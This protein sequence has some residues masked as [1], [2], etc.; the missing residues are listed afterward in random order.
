MRKIYTKTVFEF[1]PTTDTFEVNQEESEFHYIP[2]DAPLTL[3]GGSGGGDV[4]SQVSVQKNDPWAGQQPYLKQGFDQVWSAYLNDPGYF[5]SNSPESAE[6]QRMIMDRARAGSALN[7]D[8]QGMLDA[9]LRGDYLY[10][11]AG[12]DK[13]YQAAA[14]KIIPQV[15]SQFASS[16]RLNSGLAGVAKTSALGD[17]FAGLYDNERKRQL[18]ASQLAPEAAMSDYADAGMIGQ[19]GKSREAMDQ[20]NAERRRRAVADYMALIT[21]NYGSTSTSTTTN[22]STRTGGWGGAL[23]GAGSGAASGFVGS[24]GNPWGAAV[25]G[26]IGLLNS[27]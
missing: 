26:V 15:D 8:N 9:T 21:G 19:V 24:G 3:M 11:G 22:P 25:G 16:G 2:D 14:N 23:M 7:R 4:P 10:G 18:A 12:F 20:Y 6:S 27:L 17:A 13:A 1:N 5:A